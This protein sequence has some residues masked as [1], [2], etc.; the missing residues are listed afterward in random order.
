MLTEHDYTVGLHDFAMS[1]ELDV[2]LVML[3]NRICAMLMPWDRVES[4]RTMHVNLTLM[5]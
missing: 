5:R 2:G 3:K 4:E 1:L